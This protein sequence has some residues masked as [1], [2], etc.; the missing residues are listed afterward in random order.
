MISPRPLKKG[1][2]VALLA[3]SGPCEPTLLPNAI[4]FIESLDVKCHVMESCHARH[5]YLAGTDEL[6]LRDLMTAF[7]NPNINGIFAARGGY[8]ALRLLPHI[9]YALVRKNPKILAGY[10]DI[11]ALHLALNQRSKLITFHAPMP[12]SDFSKTEPDPLTLQSFRETLFSSNYVYNNPTPYIPIRHGYARA[13]LTGGNLT[14]IAATLGTPF[15]I[16]TR[17]RILFLEEINEEP[18]RIDRLFWQL[19]EARKFQDASGLLLG[20]F[21]P[22]SLHALENALRMIPANLPTLGGFSSGHTRIN[23]SL[24][25]G[26][27]ATLQVT[28]SAHQ[29]Q[30]HAPL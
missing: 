6:R 30:I 13:R 29:F 20:D 11:T 15:E 19:K 17:N 10:S 2:T 12:V 8:G 24:P 9:N 4:K 26:A 22:Y 27:F 5:E 14:V 7:A 18:Y 23:L 25:M 28:E 21:N 1:D 3:P 16:D